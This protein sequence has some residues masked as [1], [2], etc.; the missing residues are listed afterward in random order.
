[1]VVAIARNVY[2]ITWLIYEDS[3]RFRGAS[4]IE[5]YEYS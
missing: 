5:A 1:M 3:V 4:R 2:I